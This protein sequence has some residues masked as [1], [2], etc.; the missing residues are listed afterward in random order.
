MTKKGI[1]ASI[2]KQLF[3]ALDKI[4]KLERKLDEAYTNIDELKK[5]AAKKEKL[6]VK[7]YKKLESRCNKLEKTINEYS[8]GQDLDCPDVQSTLFESGV[9]IICSL[10][11]A[12]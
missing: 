4:E 10:T 12:H 6:H 1:E 8:P 9:S 3:D 11:T 5:D 2:S 7:E